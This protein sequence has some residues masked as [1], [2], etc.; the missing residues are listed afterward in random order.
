MD[1]MGAIQVN[2]QRVEVGIADLVPGYL[3]HPMPCRRGTGTRT[4]VQGQP[5]P[6]CEG[7]V[8]ALAM[9]ERA[10]CTQCGLGHT[11]VMSNRTVLYGAIL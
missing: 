9:E 10:N 8:C 2:G 7:T 11:F 3:N 4:M 6:R 1:K 5:V